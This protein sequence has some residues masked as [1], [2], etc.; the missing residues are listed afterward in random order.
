MLRYLW[1]KAPDA[2]PKQHVCGPAENMMIKISQRFHGA[3][4]MGEVLHL[5]GPY[6]SLEQLNRAVALLQRR[7]PVLRS[8]LRTHP[9]KRDCFVLEEDE[10]LRLPVEEL[11]RKREEHASFWLQEWPKREKEPINIGEPLAKL[12]LLQTMEN[13]IRNS[14]SAVNRVFTVSRLLFSII[15]TLMTN[16]LP[17]ARIPLDEVTFSIDEMDKYCH[18]E[19]VYGVLNKEMTTKLL[20]RCRREGVSITSA[21]TGAL[22]SAAASLVPVKDGQGTIMMIMLSADTRRRCAPT[23][24]N[25]DFGYYA[26]GIAPFC[27]RMSALPKTSEDSWQLAQSFGQH[28][29]ACVNAGQVLA[30]GLIN[31]KLGSLALRPINMAYLPTYGTSSWGVLPFV[32][33]YDGEWCFDDDVRWRLSSHFCDGID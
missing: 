7:H 4:R 32:E 26:S 18:T 22:S 30:S 1:R 6:I 3:M 5:Q 11:A 12:W 8:R 31:G 17:I 16:R 28:T 23:V 29:N 19:A 20:A 33:Q 10:A 15:Y 2:G 9:T 25:H 21:V 27:L 13:A 14:L 24:P